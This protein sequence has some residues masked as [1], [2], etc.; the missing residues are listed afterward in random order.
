MNN[1]SS[2]ASSTLGIP[3]A[4]DMFL[5]D[6][7][8]E[9]GQLWRSKQLYNALRDQ[10]TI[11]EAWFWQMKHFL[12]SKSAERKFFPATCWYQ[13]QY[14]QYLYHCGALCFVQDK[15]RLLPGKEPD[16]KWM[17]PSYAEAVRLLPLSGL[18]SETN[19]FTSGKIWKTGFL[20]SVRLDIPTSYGCQTMSP[21]HVLT[22]KWNAKEWQSSRSG[23]KEVGLR[24]KTAMLLLAPAARFAAKIESWYG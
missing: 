7:G 20:E 19:C 9:D 13:Y 12:K 11:T 22:K 6:V 3:S 18:D 15:V 23:R 24:W 14:H 2:K 16:L 1:R 10:N 4:Q 8:P 17:H 5:T 21:E